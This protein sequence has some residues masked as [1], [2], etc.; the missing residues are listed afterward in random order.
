MNTGLTCKCAMYGPS[1]VKEKLSA[2]QLT[3][4]FLLKM[5]T[6]TN[7][8]FEALSNFIIRHSFIPSV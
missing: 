2:H 4:I 3:V 6:K 5:K 1:H 8:K 7:Y